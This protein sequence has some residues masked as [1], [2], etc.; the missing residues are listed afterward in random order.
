[1][2]LVTHNFSY[3]ERRV[4]SGIAKAAHPVEGELGLGVEYRFVDEFGRWDGVSGVLGGV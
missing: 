2:S 3:W 1:M 4:W